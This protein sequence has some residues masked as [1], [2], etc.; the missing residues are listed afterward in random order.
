MVA[1]FWRVGMALILDESSGKD[2]L[3]VPGSNDWR[4]LLPSIRRVLSRGVL[5]I[6]AIG[7]QK[8]PEREQDYGSGDFHSESVS[9]EEKRGGRSASVLHLIGHD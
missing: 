2:A 7:C 6:L 9:H 3:E 8:M 4:K 5:G 1:G